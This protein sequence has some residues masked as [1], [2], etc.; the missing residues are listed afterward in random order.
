[1]TV[2]AARVQRNLGLE[3]LAPRPAADEIQVAAADASI[4][5]ELI[6]YD[7]L[8]A[9]GAAFAKRAPGRGLDC[10]TT[11]PSRGRR[12]WTQGSA[13]SQLGSH[14]P[15][16]RADRHMD[17]GRG[18]CAEPGDD[19]G[20]RQQVRVEALYKEFRCHRKDDVAG[21]SCPTS[22]SPRHVLDESDRK[23]AGHALQIGLA[24]VPGRACPRERGG[25]EANHRR[26][27]TIVGHH[28]R[29]R[30]RHRSDARGRRRHCE[31]FCHLRLQEGVQQIH[32]RVIC[33]QHQG[34]E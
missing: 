29:D 34:T 30:W 22:W 28:D 3:N 20:R 27:P 7:S 2:S 33:L 4:Q 31:P 15:N 21:V 17:H 13:R 26:L 16:R 10:R 11:C 1:M 8:G 32:R 14:C 24:H 18:P 5:R 23:Q 9:S 19:T 25:L 6:D 12:T